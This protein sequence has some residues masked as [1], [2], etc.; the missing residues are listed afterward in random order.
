MEV[1]TLRNYGVSLTA[2]MDTIPQKIKLGVL[3][4][5]PFAIKKRIGSTR[6]IRFIFIFLNEKRKMSHVDLKQ[7]FDIGLRDRNFMNQQ[8]DQTAMFTTLSKMMGME[9]ALSIGYEIMDIAVKK[10]YLAWLPKP[11]DFLKFSD[12]FAAFKE[13]YLAMCEALKNEGGGEPNIIENNEN[14]LHFEVYFCP[15]L[16]I[17]QILGNEKAVLLTCHVDEVALPEYCK[18]IGISYKREKAMGIGDDRCEYKFE[19]MI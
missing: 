13:W 18:K 9:K 15:W 7:I 3:L 16:Y 8:A 1:S 2:V 11:E 19:R 6:F 5:I 10:A 14:I 4:S 12:P 17:P